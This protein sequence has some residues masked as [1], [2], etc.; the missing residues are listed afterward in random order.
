MQVSELPQ[1]PETLARIPDGPFDF[2]F[3][4]TGRYVASFRIKAALTGE[5]EKA[6]KETDQATIVF[7]DGGGQVV[8]GD[9]A[10]DAT[11]R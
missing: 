3:F 11:Q 7:G 9:L 2:S 8:I 10:R 6:R 1:R 4:P 5:S